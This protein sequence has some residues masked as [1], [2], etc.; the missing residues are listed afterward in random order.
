MRTAPQFARADARNTTIAPS[1]AHAVRPLQTVSVGV[2]GFAPR[3]LEWWQAHGRKDLPWQLDPTPY[4]VWV[5][6]IMLQQTQVATAIGYYLAFMQR[7]TDVRALAAAEQEQV[8]EAWSGLGYY[9]RARNLH[10]CAQQ[11]VDEHGGEFPQ[12]LA[13]LIALR[14]I[15]R[16]TAGAILSLSYAQ[17]QPIL[18]GNVKRVLC[19]HAGIEGWPSKSSVQRALW[20]LAEQRLPDSQGAAYTQ[21]MMDLG[22]TVCT[23]RRPSCEHCPVASDCVAR[24]E[25]R[26]STLPTAKPRRAI[27][28]RT[29]IFIIARGQDGAVLLERR[30]P[31]GIWGG[32]WCFPECTD[33]AQTEA[34]LQRLGLRA[35]GAGQAL[36]PMR[37]TFSHFHLTITPLVLEVRQTRNAIA[38]DA[39]LRWF[40]PQQADTAAL[41][42]PVARLLACQ[43]EQSE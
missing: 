15:G 39:R 34:Q 43:A 22:A 8:L 24:N 5:S 33:I 19:R 12:S 41:A 21:A 18:D 27:P 29:T 37:H 40:Y 38:D 36:A 17:V 35:R 11:I 25:Q 3:M 20:A 2:S 7:F 10:H 30:P 31:T 26:I 28:Q 4:R 13:A 32:L 42:T 16:S 1:T 23:A 9:A 6:E 14:G